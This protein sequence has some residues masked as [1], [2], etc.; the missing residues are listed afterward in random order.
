MV[1]SK[2]TCVGNGVYRVEYTPTEVGQ[3]IFNLA[4]NVH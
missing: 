4:F 1:R 2:M 3:Y